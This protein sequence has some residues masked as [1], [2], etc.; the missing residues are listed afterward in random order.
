[1]YLS[2][3][4]KKGEWCQGILSWKGGYRGTILISWCAC[5]ICVCMCTCSCYFRGISSIYAV[6]LTWLFLAC[7]IFGV[8][9]GKNSF[10]TKLWWEVLLEFLILHTCKSYQNILRSNPSY[11]VNRESRLIKTNRMDR[12]IQLIWWSYNVNMRI[13]LTTIVK[14]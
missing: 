14:T 3:S 2:I 10:I 1:M 6:G 4:N 13:V 5:T 7:M 12:R 11:W 8:V 9:Y